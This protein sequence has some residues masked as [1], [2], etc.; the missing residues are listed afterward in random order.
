M[1]E[2]TTGPWRIG[3]AGVTVFGP[4]N[5]NPSPKTV[6]NVKSKADAKLI[7]AAPELLDAA[8]AALDYYAQT[9]NDDAP[10]AVELR[11]AIAKATK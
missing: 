5:G 7:A 9:G 1:S 2:H 10:T 3:D 8:M 6:A 4:P 11:A